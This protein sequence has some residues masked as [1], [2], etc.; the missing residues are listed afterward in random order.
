MFSPEI[1]TAE[2]VEGLDRWAMCIKLNDRVTFPCAAAIKCFSQ[3]LRVTIIAMLP[4]VA[5]ARKDNHDNY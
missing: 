2:S 1:K 4:I 5:L 3:C